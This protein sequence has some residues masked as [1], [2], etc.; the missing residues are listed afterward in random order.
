MTDSPLHLLGKKVTLGE[1]GSTYVVRAVTMDGEKA[2]VSL[3]VDPKYVATALISDLTPLDMITYNDHA[4]PRCGQKTVWAPA[5]GVAVCHN[6]GCGAYWDSA[7][8]FFWA[9]FASPSQGGENEAA[10]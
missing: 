2:I 9:V 7:E 6:A 5:Q 10:A 8:D 4:C 1:T 3:A